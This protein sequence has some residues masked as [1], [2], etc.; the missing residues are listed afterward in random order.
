MAR[1]RPLLQTLTLACTLAL[2]AAAR[3]S[4]GPPDPL[5]SLI[6]REMKAQ[7]IPGVAVAVIEDGK[8]ILARAWGYSNLETGTPLDTGAVFELAS[9][10][11]QFSAAA[12]L[13]LAEE[14]KVG[15]D[16]PISEYVEGTPDS[17]AKI[18]V[19]MLLSHTSGLPIDGFP[20][21]Q[22]SP[23][24]LITTRQAFEFIVKRPLIYPPGEGA[25]YSD[26]GYFLAG[27][28]IEKASGQSYRAFMQRIFDRAGMTSSSI[29]DK[30][31]ILKGR[32]ST[33]E[34]RDGQLLNWRRDWDH[35]LPSFFG[36][37][38]TLNDMA[39][40]DQA[41]RRATILTR[42]SLDEMWTPAKLANG[43][44]A[45][46]FDQL[47]G[48]GW[49]LGDVAGHRTV[50]HGGASGTYFLRF[51]DRPVS[52]VV[53]TNRGVNGRNPMMLAEAVAGTLYPDLRPPQLA[54]PVADPDESLTARVN[55]L[56][57]DLVAKQESR[58]TT[59]TY[60]AWYTTT[61]QAWRNLIGNA[62]GRAGA[63][64]HLMTV[65]IGGKSLW[66]M[67][68]IERLVYYAMPSGNVTPRLTVGVTKA[69]EIARVD[70][71]PR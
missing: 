37:F 57:A 2:P 68:P 5:D 16:E 71:A 19:R 66:G 70:F 47:Y 49:N 48:L 63:A 29:L 50:G 51:M 65:N 52:I 9:V 38:S 42:K 41:L 55:Q 56:V 24:L 1:V 31:R 13:L 62:L 34:L 17:W 20:D 44:P 45:R 10:T 30:R 25:F 14:G 64:K 53:L 23:L 15:L 32:V 27:M 33:Y 12:L 69:G 43:Q 40:W 18:T 22:G 8:M 6:R 28:V 39:R 54:E 61:P 60:R 59:A 36:V 26:A 11:K 58:V 46:V 35:E 67:E 3:Q 4:S 21:Y 7:Q